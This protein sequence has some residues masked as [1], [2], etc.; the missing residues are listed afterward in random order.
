MYCIQ[1]GGAGELKK[2]RKRWGR[3]TKAI[4]AKWELKGKKRKRCNVFLSLL[5]LRCYSTPFSF[6]LFSVWCDVSARASCSTIAVVF[7]CCC[8]CPLC[9]RDCSPVQQSQY[10]IKR[11]ESEEVS[12]RPFR[13]P[14]AP[15]FPV[16]FSNHFLAD[17][18][19]TRYN[20]FPVL[21]IVFFYI[22]FS[23]SLSI[24]KHSSAFVF[25]PS[26]SLLSP[27]CAY[28]YSECVCVPLLYIEL[29]A[30]FLYSFSSIYI[31]MRF[32]CFPLSLGECRI[33]NSDNDNNSSSSISKNRAQQKL[34]VDAGRQNAI[35]SNGHQRR[36]NIL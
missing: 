13:F 10:H 30:F 18:R 16:S 17:D 34:I 14:H 33:S 21:S 24:S 12:Q 19:M 26:I 35:F 36:I 23:V 11:S 29:V 1:N 22:L 6:S 3:E 27:S 20:I 7:G 5:L 28:I 31:Y 8:C 4:R 32:V 15:P 9:V 2:S 25:L